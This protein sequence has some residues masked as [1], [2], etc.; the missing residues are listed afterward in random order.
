MPF[1]RSQGSARIG[2]YTLHQLVCGASIKALRL[3][4]LDLSPKLMYLKSE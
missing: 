3:C 4:K 1:I 2:H